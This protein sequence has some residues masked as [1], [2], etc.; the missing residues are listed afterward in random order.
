MQSSPKAGFRLL[1]EHELLEAVGFGLCID[2]HRDQLRTKFVGFFA[3]PC[4]D[5]G[6]GCAQIP[7]NADRERDKAVV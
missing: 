3:R 4:L 6:S 7:S 2:V 5:Y 1:L